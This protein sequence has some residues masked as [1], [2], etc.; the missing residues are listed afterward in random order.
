MV[1]RVESDP[2]VLCGK[3]VWGWDMGGGRRVSPRP[4]P[5]WVRAWYRP[6]AVTR[7]Q[8][9]NMRR[10]LLSP[11]PQRP[12]PGCPCRSRAPAAPEAPRLARQAA[13]FAVPHAADALKVARRERGVVVRE[14]RGPLEGCQAGSQERACREAAAVVHERDARRARVVGVLGELLQDGGAP[15][16]QGRNACGA[17]PRAVSP[18]APRSCVPAPCSHRG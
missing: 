9:A 7:S 11:S 5:G 12:P 14:Q 8:A 17:R 3:C 6:A 16:V 10:A 13:L 2:V 15:G 1:H 18:A 4:P